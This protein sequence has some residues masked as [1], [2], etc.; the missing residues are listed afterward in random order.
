VYGTLDA[1]AATPRVRV[2]NETN[3]AWDAEAQTVA[4]SAD[5]Y[6]AV[7]A[8]APV[9]YE[10]IAAFLTSAN[11]LNVL[12][13]KNGSWTSEWSITTGLGAANVTRRG[14]AAA[15]EQLSQDA[16]V[17]YTDNGNNPV[18]RTWNGTSWSGPSA[19]FATPPG[20]GV[21]QWIELA[22]DPRSDRIA[23]VY[24]DTSNDVFAA[25]WNGT[26]WDQTTKV[27]LTTNGNTFRTY[28]DVEAAYENSGDLLV[29]FLSAAT[30][31]VAYYTMAAGTTT[32]VN[33]GAVDAGLAGSAAFLDLAPE[34]GGDRMAL[35]VVVEA[36]GACGLG[37]AV[38]NGAAWVNN[39]QVWSQANCY[40]QADA[41]N[42]P[43]WAA[44]G[45]AGKSGTA[46]LTFGH[47]TPGRWGGS[48][49]R[50]APAG[51]PSRTCPSPAW[52]SRSGRC[53]SSPIGTRRS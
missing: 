26:A 36:G 39:G 4:A 48:G 32:W 24:S 16:L 30:D 8:R 29:A 53:R 1:P 35:G 23:L 3:A 2:W 50:P 47:P 7:S 43:F 18:F 40:W 19:V 21:V 33:G 46:V 22:S 20:T 51:W 25:I 9:R 15:Y 38:W 12:R 49:G 5:V 31:D 14:V 10:E 6:H 28:R 34:P 42:G 52:P 13:W 45:W 44:A 37:A 41:V 11:Q 27:T 17:V